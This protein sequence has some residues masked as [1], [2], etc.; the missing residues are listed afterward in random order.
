MGMRNGLIRSGPAEGVDRHA[1]HEGPDPAEPGPE[2]DPGPLGER[3]LEALGQA[4]LVHRLAGGH[5]AELDVAVGAALVLAVEHAG[6]RRSRWTS[7][8]IRAVSRD[9]SKASIV[10]MPTARRRARPRSSRTSLPSGGEHAH[11]GHDDPRRRRRSR[12]HRTS[13]PA[14]HGRGPIDVA[15]EAARADRVGDRQRIELGPADLRLDR[16][17]RR[18]R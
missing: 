17:R 3:A 4:G 8:A 10:R 12:R 5:E 16:R 1:V 6:W 15:G 9:G 14:A 7:P 18:C 11:A 2:D 13:L